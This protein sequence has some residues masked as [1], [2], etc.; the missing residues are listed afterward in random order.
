MDALFG[1]VTVDWQTKNLTKWDI[2]THEVMDV[3]QKSW[4]LL[5]QPRFMISEGQILMNL[6]KKK[7]CTLACWNN[8]VLKAMIKILEETQNSFS[9]WAFTNT[10]Q[11]G[12]YES[13]KK[14]KMDSGSNLNLPMWTKYFYRW[15][16]NWVEW[17]YQTDKYLSFW[18]FFCDFLAFLQ[19]EKIN[20]SH[21]KNCLLKIIIMEC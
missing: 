5:F 13:F 16:L 18:S 15:M 2:W 9:F 17:W 14:W 12:K 1:D 21:I 7:L 3:Y 20:I 8:K 11:S 10:L 19:L 6:I 4:L